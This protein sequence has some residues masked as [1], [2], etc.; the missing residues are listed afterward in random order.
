MD[1][2]VIKKRSAVGKT[3]VKWKLVSL[4]PVANDEEAPEPAAAIEGPDQ[5]PIPISFG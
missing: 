2:D 4:R 5:I 1:K 3:G